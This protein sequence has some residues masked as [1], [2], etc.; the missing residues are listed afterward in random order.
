MSADWPL[1]PLGEVLKHRKEFVHIDDMQQYKRCRVQ[2]HAQ[3]IVL[4]DA[5]P[6]AEI[7]TKKQQVCKAGEFLVAEID[8]KLGGFGIV[9]DDLEGAIVSSHYFLY[10]I[11]DTKL[12]RRFLDLYIRTPEFREQD[13]VKLLALGLPR[14]DELWPKLKPIVESCVKSNDVGVGFKLVELYANAD[15]QLAPKIG[16]LL[17]VRWKAAGNAKLAHASRAAAVRDS[18]VAF[19]R[20]AKISHAE[21]VSQLQE[22]LGKSPQYPARPGGRQEGASASRK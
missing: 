2:L 20:A 22:L 1:V 8:A 13:D 19:A 6:G 5:I 7:K 16:E 12:D 3:G 21:R 15:A 14:G 4:R 11:I 10:G 17:A 9:P 18:M